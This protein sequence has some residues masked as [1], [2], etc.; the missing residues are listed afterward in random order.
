M[1][2]ETV[3]FF[4][5]CSSIRVK[6]EAQVLAKCARTFLEHLFSEPEME[7]S[8]LQN[9]ICSLLLLLL[10]VVVLVDATTLLHCCYCCGQHGF[11]AVAACC[12]LLVYVAVYKCVAVLLLL[13]LFFF[14]FNSLLH[15]FSEGNQMQDLE[16]EL[17]LQ[18]QQIKD[19]RSQLE[20]ERKIREMLVI[21]LSDEQRAR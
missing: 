2:A 18:Q 15:L 13:L 1:A 16:N 12:F 17:E 9:L 5:R 4:C 6:S 20:K 8:K 10:F 11:V 21:R 7:S 3:S 19:L 14:Q